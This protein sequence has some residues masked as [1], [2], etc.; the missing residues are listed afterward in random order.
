MESEFSAEGCDVNPVA[1]EQATSSGAVV[2]ELFYDSGISLGQRF[3]A[4][5]MVDV[6]EHFPEPKE[7]LSAVRSSL[8]PGGVLILEV[9]HVNS[10]YSRVLGKRWWFGLEHCFYYTLE[11]LR[12][13]AADSGF[14]L[15]T[16]ESDNINLLSREGLCRLGLFGED[17]VWGRVA[18]VQVC[19]WKKTLARFFENRA[20]KTLNSALNAL[21]RRA[22]LGDQLR[23]VLRVSTDGLVCPS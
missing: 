23:I 16:W 15:E 14:R 7:V 2:R 10:L 4:M 5:T 17:L 18:E 8:K 21:G 11:S 20:M 12:R 1:L 3:D 6:F 22:G 13:L 9:P 19:G